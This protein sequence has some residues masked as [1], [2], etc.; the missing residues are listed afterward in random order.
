M[1]IPVN[2]LPDYDD[3]GEKPG[4][5]HSGLATRRKVP[6]HEIHGRRCSEKHDYGKGKNN[7]S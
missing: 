7:E 5:L 1:K 6:S 4:D 2:Q 3:F